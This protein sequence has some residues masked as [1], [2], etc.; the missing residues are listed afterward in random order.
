MKYFR[1]LRIYLSFYLKLDEKYLF[2][3]VKLIY[4][5]Y[6]ILLHQTYLFNSLY[7]NFLGCK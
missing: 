5:I 7:F 4:K 6:V 1:D 2:L 3:T